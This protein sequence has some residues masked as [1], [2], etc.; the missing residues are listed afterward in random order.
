MAIMYFTTKFERLV[1]KAV[2]IARKEVV[3]SRRVIMH[4]APVKLFPVIGG[5]EITRKE[6]HLVK[7]QEDIITSS[8][9]RRSTDFANY[10]RDLDRNSYE[11]IE[12][13]KNLKTLFE[14]GNISEE[15]L[16][17]LIDNPLINERL[18]IGIYP[19]S[20]GKI[21]FYNKG[22]EKKHLSRR[23]ETYFM[24]S[25]D[26]PSFVKKG[27]RNKDL[28]KDRDFVLNNM[29]ETL[30]YSMKAASDDRLSL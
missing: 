16:S 14:E 12:S 9:D 3:P 11:I 30:K 8:Y 23:A 1:E 24:D 10:C 5:D 4:K 20:H 18:D 26:I 15:Q 7:E 28:D 25:E 17:N 21:S 2:D 19:I 22:F 6:F 27:F 13:G 29:I